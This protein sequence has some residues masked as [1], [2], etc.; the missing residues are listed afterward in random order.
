[1][2][3]WSLPSLGRG[4]AGT[5]KKKKKKKKLI[6]KEMYVSAQAVFFYFCSPFLTP[7]NSDVVELRLG[8]RPTNW[9][10]QEE[11]AQP[12]LGW[13][14]VLPAH[15]GRWPVGQWLPWKLPALPLSRLYI[16]SLNHLCI[17]NKSVCFVRKVWKV[18][19]SSRG[20]RGAF[21]HRLGGRAGRG[22]PLRWA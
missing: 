5:S 20:L 2:A 18:A 13:P 22:T 3:F 14:P 1:M 15:P 7:P 16:N 17:E 9:A 6:N 11:Q 12:R 19:K 21:S 4:L 10:P 8:P